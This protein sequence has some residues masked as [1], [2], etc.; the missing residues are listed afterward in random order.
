MISKATPELRPNSMKLL[1]SPLPFALCL[2]CTTLSAS[3]AVLVSNLGEPTGT[4]VTSTGSMIGN[5]YLATSF[6][7]GPDASIINGAE[8]LVRTL[9][10]ETSV[11]YQLSI[12][13][14]VGGS[15]SSSLGTFDTL[16]T[17]PTAV[18]PTS[19]LFSDAGIPLAANTTYWLALR[20]TDTES[21]SWY[22]TLSTAETSSSG[23][24]ISDSNPSASTDGGG[25]WSPFPFAVG[26]GKFALN[27]T[28]VP[29]PGAM[30]GSM[31]AIPFLF[32]RSRRAR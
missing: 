17:L 21:L 24:T 11:T 30:M 9:P 2:T 19:I 1:A 14:D 8:V 20:S 16:P 32:R 26:P 22:S 4:P 7:T 3:A 12:W 31:L 13:S 5:R 28:A 29:E 15:P 6:T 10:V 23:W 18:V 25:S 27:G